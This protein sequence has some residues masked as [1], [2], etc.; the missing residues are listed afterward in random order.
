M[1]GKP[2][3]TAVKP[4][5]EESWGMYDLKPPLRKTWFNKTSCEEKYSLHS[6]PFVRN[7]I[8]VTKNLL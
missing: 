7:T 2:R 5:S 6:K 8:S 1:A 3:V 4:L